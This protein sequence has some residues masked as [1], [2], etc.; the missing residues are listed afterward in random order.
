[1]KINTKERKF[2]ISV[3]GDEDQIVHENIAFGKG[4]DYY[5]AVSNYTNQD[6]PFRDWNCIELV[7]FNR[8]LLN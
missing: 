2:V 5:M 8:R 7:S 1:M 4:T 6:D 3:N